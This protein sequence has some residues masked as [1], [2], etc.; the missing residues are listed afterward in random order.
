[1]CRYSRAAR[2]GIYLRVLWKDCK[3]LEVFV[4]GL[5]P[6]LRTMMRPTRTL[7][8]STAYAGRTGRFRRVDWLGGRCA[9]G[10]GRSRVPCCVR[11]LA[12]VVARPW[13]QAWI[14]CPRSADTLDCA[15]MCFNVIHIGFIHLQCRGAC[16]AGSCRAPLR[17]WHSSGTHH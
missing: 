12:V 1:M 5:R 9:P 17:E 8:I 14:P 4:N 6:R 2:L 11:S 3:M 16:W 10:A 15:L 7:L 13:D